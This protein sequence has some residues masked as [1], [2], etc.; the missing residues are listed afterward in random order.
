MTKPI[1]LVI[2]DDPVVLNA[3]ERDLRQKYGAQY[4]IT[5]VNLASSALD[6]LK[7]VQA[8]GESVAL[9]VCDQRMPQMTGV[10]FL[11]QARTLYP[12][13][14]KVL[15]TAYADTEAAIAA[16]NR[17]GLD[18]YL[19]KPWDPP[20]EKLYPVLDELLDDWQARTQVPGRLSSDGIRVAGTLWSLASHQI[21]DFLVRHQLPYQYLDVE[22]DP[23]A[24]AL[25]EAQCQGELRIPTVFFPDGTVLIEPALAQVA[26]K[27]GL[28][29]KAAM[30][31]YDFIIIGAGPAGL[32]AAVYASSEGLDCLLVERHAPGGQAGSSPKIENY[33]G[34]PTGISGG[35]LTRRA[36][37]QARRLG[38]EIVTAQAVT[39]IRLLD[40]Y[41]IVT[42]ASGAEIS[43]HALLLAT[44]ASFS[45]LKMTGAAELTGKGIYYG[46]AHTEAYY[47]KD[48]AVFVVGGANSAAQ[49]A[50]F[51][52]RYARQVT[53]LIRGPELSSAQHLVNALVAD[54]K[55]EIRLNTDLVEAHGV[56]KLEGL[57]VRQTVTGETQTLPGEA[58][59][60]FIGVKPQSEL[61]AGLAQ[62]SPD[63]Y[64][65]TGQDVLVG[66][67]R[68][69][70]GPLFRDPLPFETS[71]PGLFA[72][73]DV[74]FGTIHRVVSA[75]AEGGAAVAMARQY[76]KTL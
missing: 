16:I 60:V 55:I 69:A 65:L 15:L 63:G 39:G 37:T 8:R 31:F 70:G 13:A 24:R 14:G 61:V 51:L 75:T 34:F 30:K 20:E 33:L 28:P 23:R 49:G 32:S 64:V 12:E 62:L 5:K 21:K 19:M 42:L 48:Q 9:F 29:T 43:S 25:V 56:E 1:I 54:P 6:Y 76:L 26:E 11:E 18:H 38:A 47:Y 73:G 44:G 22:S 46:A 36:M 72:A 3:V 41:K 66:G 74:R 58:L 68:P 27:A 35:D 52:S 45:T 53:M 59:F 4:R 57:T 67:Q 50:L 17:V 71:V 7:Q 2:D 10:K 40:L